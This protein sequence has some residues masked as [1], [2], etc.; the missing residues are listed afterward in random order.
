MIT[1]IIWT[2]WTPMSSVPQKADKLNLSLSFLYWHSYLHILQ[3]LVRTRKFHTRPA[4]PVDYSMVGVWCR[5]TYSK[6]PGDY[7]MFGV[8]F[9]V[10]HSM[11]RG[12]YSMVGVWCWI[13]HSR[14]L[15]DY[16]MVGVWCRVTYS[17]CSGNYSMLGIWS[18]VIPSGCLG[19]YNMVDAWYR[20]LILSLLKITVRLMFDVG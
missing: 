7:S 6:G 15:E 14:C 4:L 19:N 20:E 3:V 12:D 5:V 9:R 17:R 2:I 18:R 11:C 10:N 16:S 13:T 1:R 8:W